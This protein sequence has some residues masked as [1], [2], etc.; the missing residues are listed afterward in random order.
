MAASQQGDQA[1]NV[2][3][4]VLREQ[5]SKGIKPATLGKLY[6]GSKPARG[7]SQQRWASCTKGAS[8]QGDQA[9]NVGQAVLRQQASKGIKPATLGKLYYGSK[10]ARG[11]SQQRWASCTKPARGSSQQRWASCTA[12]Q[13]GDQASNVGQAVLWQQASKGIKQATLG[14]LY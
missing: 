3:Q 14:K 12:S 6:Y 5:A 4:A 11:S 9:S 2:G 1:S 10:P 7:S 13:Q 8:Q